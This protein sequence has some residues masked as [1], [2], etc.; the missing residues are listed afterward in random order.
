MPNGVFHKANLSPSLN[1]PVANRIFILE[2]QWNPSIEAQAIARA[3][4]PGQQ[5]SVRV[6]RYIVS[7]SVEE[8]EPSVVHPPSL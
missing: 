7:R 6:I 1:L 5:E 2:P 4:R 8:V 3:L